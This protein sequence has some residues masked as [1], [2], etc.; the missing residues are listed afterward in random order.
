MTRCNPQWVHDAFHRVFLARNIPLD[1]PQRDPAWSPWRSNAVVA[2][3]IA[4]ES[5]ESAR[6][7]REQTKTMWKTHGFLKMMYFDD[8]LWW[9]VPFSVNFWLVPKGK[10]RTVWAHIAVPG[11]LVERCWKCIMEYLLKLRPVVYFWC[12]C[13]NP[14]PQFTDKFKFYTKRWLLQ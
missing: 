5:A 4:S 14:V 3:G 7:R 8:R 11:A 2:R 6:T 10:C 13:L 1:P 12:K 9:I